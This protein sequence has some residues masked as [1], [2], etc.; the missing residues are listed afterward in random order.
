MFTLLNPAGLQAVHPARPGPGGT[1]SPVSEELESPVITGI[2]RVPSWDG[3]AGDGG[4]AARQFGAALMPAGFRCSGDLLAHLS[5][6][7][8]GVVIDVAVRVLCTVRQIV[9]VHVRTTWLA[10]LGR[11]T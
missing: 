6:L 1:D 9:V 11:P 8:A 7:D 3:P 5:G 2:H 4:V 10:G